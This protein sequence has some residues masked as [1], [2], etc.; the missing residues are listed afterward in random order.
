ML[1]SPVNVKAERVDIYE[2]E[3]E[4]ILLVD[5]PDVSTH[6]V[7]IDLKDDLLS[8]VG[9]VPAVMETCEEVLRK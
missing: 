1:L 9:R 5:M 3:N 6:H 2:A 4:L 7:E 8:S